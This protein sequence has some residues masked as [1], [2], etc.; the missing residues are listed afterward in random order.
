MTTIEKR[1]SKVAII[2]LGASEFSR[3]GG[4]SARALAAEGCVNAISDAGMTKKDIEDRKSV[5]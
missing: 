3:S 5:V 4:T 2:G 1:R